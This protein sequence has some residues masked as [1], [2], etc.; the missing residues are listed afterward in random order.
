[1]FGAGQK[2]IDEIVAARTILPEL[3][4]SALEP[5]LSLRAQKALLEL[6]IESFGNLAFLSLKNVVSVK[7]NGRGSLAEIAEI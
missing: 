6:K 2:P 7:G 4:F 3:G 5:P 1:M